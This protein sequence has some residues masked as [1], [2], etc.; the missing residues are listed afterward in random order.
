V[1]FQQIYEKEHMQFAHKK[2]HTGCCKEENMSERSHNHN[3]YKLMEI[4]WTCR[5]DKHGSN[6]K[7]FSETAVTGGQFFMDLSCTSLGSQV[8]CLIL[9]LYLL[10]Q[11]CKREKE[12][13]PLEN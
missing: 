4:N 1:C 12:E 9:L 3:K 8:Y 10:I 11:I 5:S 13:Q 2:E 6:E 7:Q